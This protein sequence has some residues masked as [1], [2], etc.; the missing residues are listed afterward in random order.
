M[1]R[2]LV[3]SSMQL[4]RDREPGCRATARSREQLVGGHL[5]KGHLVHLQRL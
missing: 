3:A 5:M 4:G 1:A 2:R